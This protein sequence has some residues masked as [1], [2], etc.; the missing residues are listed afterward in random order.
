MLHR[1]PLSAPARAVAIT[2]SAFSL[3]WIVSAPIFAQEAKSAPTHAPSTS[4]SAASE[5][6][7]GVYLGRKKVGYNVTRSVP[8]T[9]DSRPA[10]KETT[11]GVVKL[12]MLGASLE[13]DEDSVSISDQKHRPLKQ[14]LDVKS[15]GA[16]LHVEAIY[17]YDERKIYCTVG[18]GDSATHKT[19]D[20]P[21]G[22]NFATDTSNLTA[23]QELVVGKTLEF[24]YLRPLAVDIHSAK[25]EVKSKSTIRDD[26]GKSIVAYEIHASLAEGDM[27]GWADKDGN[28]IRSELPLGDQT[29]TT[30]RETHDHAVDVAYITPALAKAVAA[31]PEAPTDFADA[32]A[33][34]PDRVLPD[35]RAMRYLKVTI[36]GVPAQNIVPSDDRQA[37]KRDSS[38]DTGGVTADY[39]IRAE[40]FE[41]A[42]ASQ[43]PVRGAAFAPY[44][45]KAAFLETDDAPIQETAARIRGKETNLYVIASHLRDWVHNVMTPDA[46]IGVVR[47]AKDVY[48]R[49]RGVCRDYATLYTALARAAGIP[50]RLC[51]GIVYADGKFFYHAWAE[52]YVGRWVAFDPTLYDAAKAKYVDATHIKFAQG[53]VTQMFE[54]VSIVGR[55]KIHVV[56]SDPPAQDARATAID[57][58][59]S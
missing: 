3:P 43:W 35:P 31:A 58:P 50:T 38:A 42:D 9:Y 4:E 59:A 24:Y 11:H 40:R 36:S 7:E 34:K 41:A 45:T 19:L 32:T 20:I 6:W 56:E 14:I 54:V 29:M 15:N 10:I 48:N 26:S 37:C 55:L 22:A 57:K 18:A 5:E 8:V 1:N 53:D 27:T 46:S 17:K 13:E 2:I 47:S 52:S 51:A 44:L 28:L 12:T 39:T 23:G 16:A 21:K 30:V 49:R 25:I 33:L